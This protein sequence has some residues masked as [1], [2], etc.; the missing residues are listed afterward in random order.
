MKAGKKKFGPLSI[1]DVYIIKKLLLT[2]ILAIFL[3]IM[4]AII[5]DLSERLDDFISNNAP[6]KGLIF[7]FYSSFCKFIWTSLLFHCSCVCMF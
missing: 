1:L 5:F 6:I 7:D 3:I 2:F 4:I